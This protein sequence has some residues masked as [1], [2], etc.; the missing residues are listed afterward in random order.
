MDEEQPAILDGVPTLDQ[1]VRD[2]IR[3]WVQSTGVK[4]TQLAERI[5]RNQPWVTRYLKGEFNADLDT[6]QKIAQAFGH[7]LAAL[8]D[9]PRDPLD[10][11]MLEE[12]H[13]APL[14]LRLSVI[15]MLKVVR[16]TRASKIQAPPTQ[17][18]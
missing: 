4:Q 15:E 14:R 8:V 9:Q 16:V 7:T 18:E 11:K 1:Q 6:L 13:A 12:F 17:D 3:M 2:R 10:A 5:G